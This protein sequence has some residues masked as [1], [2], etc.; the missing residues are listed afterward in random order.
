MVPRQAWKTRGELLLALCVAIVAA[1]SFV[2]SYGRWLDPVIDSGRDLYIPELLRSGGLL[3]REILYFYPPLTPYL[4]AAITALTGSSLFAYTCIGAAI[5]LTTAAVLWTGARNLAGPVAA[6]MTGLLFFSFNM[7]GP[8]G[9]GNNYFHPYAHAA[10]LG[11]LFFLAAVAAFLAVDRFRYAAPLGTLCCLLAA[12]TKIEYIAFATL[13][14]IAVVA[15]R[16]VR[17][18]WLAAFLAIGAVSAI[19]VARSL[20]F[21]AFR[22]N[23][24]PPALLGGDAAKLFYLQVTGLNAWPHNLA[25]S[26]RGAV[27]IAAFVALLAALQREE[28]RGATAGILLGAAV[29][30]AL[31]QGETMFRAW[32]VLQLVLLP[33]AL[34]R[35]REPLAI[36]L[37]ASL[38]ASSRIYLNLAP[39]WYGIVFTL[40]LYLLIVY[41]LFEWLPSRNVYSRRAALLWIPLFALTAAGAL[42]SAHRMY[43]TRDYPVAS[44]RGT[45]RDQH[46]RGSVIERLLRELERSPPASMVVM[47]EGLTLNYLARI[48]TPIRQHTFTPAESASA[49]VE[50]EILRELNAQPPD[51]VVL[52]TRD[53]REFGS[54]GFG[55]DYN[56][57]VLEW[58]RTRYRIDKGWRSPDGFT[59][60][61][62]RLGGSS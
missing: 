16:R 42:L 6:A 24:F 25:T 45:Y 43:A 53:V 47:P 50:A 17:W 13:L 55:I 12:W 10:T 40:P 57:R 46:G 21:T 31:L 29:V 56:Q 39:Y 2:Q 48:P 62:M 32:S 5:A 59:V 33:F 14:M 11:M 60:L 61:L 37:V 36:L 3:Y 34:R 28:R 18:A 58:V 52:V 54:Q 38:C 23:V 7:A 22:A 20:G 49:R 1:V 44:A 26:L 8:N 51:A 4:L 35:P 27:L 19:V 30:T 41:V 9:W 15:V